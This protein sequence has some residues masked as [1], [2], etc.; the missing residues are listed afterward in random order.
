VLKPLLGKDILVVF[1]DE[2]QVIRPRE[3][4]TVDEIGAWSRQ[5][6]RRHHRLAL[7]GSFR[8][9]GSK[10]YTDWVD[11][12]LYGSPTVWSGADDYD[13]AT[14]QD[15]FEL[16]DWI[17][18]ATSHGHLARTAAGFCWPWTRDSSLHPDVS[19]PVADPVTGRTRAWTAAWNSAGTVTRPDGTV[20]VPRSQMWAT[21]PGGHLQVG[22]IYT[23]Q[24]LEYH[25]AGTIIG[26]D[27]TWEN[28]R[29]T[30]H[31]EASRDSALKGLPPR[32]Y[33]TYAL[34]IYRVLL[35]RGTHAARVHSTDP[36]TQ[37]M[38]ASLIR[39]R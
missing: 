13:L 39:V 18:Q 21:Q 14:C 16:H 36:A 10:S 5:A 1:L 32:D 33:L 20:Q 26:P 27:L 34:N 12:L 30:A 11:R 37:R 24:G 8:C 19:I 4:I 29:W 7:T 17:E 15:P 3:G 6:G 31:P 2:R 23:A 22:C 28:G 35:T 38:L 9:A 25:H